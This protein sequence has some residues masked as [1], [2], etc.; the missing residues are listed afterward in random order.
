MDETKCPLRKIDL[1]GHE[2]QG[3]C[4]TVGCAWW[5]ESEQK[6]SVV[7]IAEAVVQLKPVRVVHNSKLMH[8]PV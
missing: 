1:G 5:I 3:L 4:V 8:H 6:C 7:V 2:M